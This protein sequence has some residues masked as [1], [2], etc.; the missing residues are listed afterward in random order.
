[1]TMID[2][3]TCDDER[4]CH[5]RD[6]GHHSLLLGICN[7]T[8]RK[9][10]LTQSTQLSWLNGLSVSGFHWNKC[11]LKKKLRRNHQQSFYSSQ[12][13]QGT[14]QSRAIRWAAS[15]ILSDS[16]KYCFGLRRV[17]LAKP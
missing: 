14:K 6:R 8:L 10:I 1:M 16:Q 2:K 15:T 4:T 13:A 12:R 5:W 9:T 11:P 7:K 3:R 17:C